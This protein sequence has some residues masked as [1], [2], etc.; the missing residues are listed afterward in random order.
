[1]SRPR[2]SSL[3]RSN[4]LS[5]LED[6]KASKKALVEAELKDAISALRKPNRQV[7]GKAMAEAEERRATTS[8][9]AKSEFSIVLIRV[10]STQ[11]TFMVRSQED[12]EELLG[13]FNPGQG[14]T[15]E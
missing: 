1:M 11:L 12:V 10:N 7:V 4:S 5:N 14:Y 13:F 2:Q 8:L 3:S 15:G 6:A 9:S